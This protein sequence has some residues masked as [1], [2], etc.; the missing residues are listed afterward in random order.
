MSFV[1]NGHPP[2]T[3]AN[4]GL[5]PEGGFKPLPPLLPSTAEDQTMWFRPVGV[6]HHSR[7]FR[8]HPHRKPPPVCSQGPRRPRRLSSALCPC[9]EPQP[10]RG[11]AS[12]HD[13]RCASDLRV[14]A[15]ACGVS[16]GA[17]GSLTPPKP[18]ASVTERVARK[19]FKGQNPPPPPPSGQLTPPRKDFSVNNFPRGGG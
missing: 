7:G 12:T 4:N 1:M 16:P 5:K 8:F 10:L 14:R 9:C 3:W 19:H 6:T 2:C 11:V 13:P 17:P 18:E 15:F